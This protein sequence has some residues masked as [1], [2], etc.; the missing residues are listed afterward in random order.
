MPRASGCLRDQSV[1]QAAEQVGVGARRSEGET[2]AGGGLDDAGCDLEKPEPDR[3]ELGR[4]QIARLWDGIAHGEDEPIGGGVE[5]EAD[6]VGE[7][8]AATGA[9]GG[10]LGLVQL[11]QVLGLSA[12][13]IEVIIDSLS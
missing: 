9:I 12:S 10:E 4:C 11:D 6:L 5:D 2:D 8:R 1:C 13:A 3:V 7:R